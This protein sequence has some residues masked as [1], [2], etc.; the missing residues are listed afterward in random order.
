MTDSRFY[1]SKPVEEQ[2]YIA[3][4]TEDPNILDI[5]SNSEHVTIRM[6]VLSNPYVSEETLMR[7][8]DDENSQVW[9]K[10]AEIL[11]QRRNSGV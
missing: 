10:A 2:T 8:I 4:K 1:L 3:L 6:A 9:S 7:K 5:L 11:E